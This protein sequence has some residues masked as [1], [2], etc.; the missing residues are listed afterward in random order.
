MSERVTS[1]QQ[2]AEQI[3]DAERRLHRRLDDIAA[4]MIALMERRGLNQKELAARVGKKESYVSRVLGGG[5]NLTQKTIAEFEAALDADIRVPLERR[6]RPP[7]RPGTGDFEDG[8]RTQKLSTR[9]MCQP[10]CMNR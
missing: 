2:D 1:L 5:V 9:S 7:R 6:P 4:R 3:P 8:R 10:G